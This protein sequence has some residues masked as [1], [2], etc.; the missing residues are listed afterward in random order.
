MEK[1]K[2]IYIAALRYAYNKQGEGFTWGDLQNELNL[3]NQQMS[4]VQ[5][6]LRSNM[7]IKDNLVDHF[8]Q[9][10]KNPNLL[11]LTQKGASEAL[12]YIKQTADRNKTYNH[13]VIFEV[14]G[15]MQM[16][17][18]IQTDKDAIVVAK[19]K[20]NYTSNKGK[21]IQGDLTS[22]EWYER[23]SGILMLTIASGLVIAFLIFKFGW[24]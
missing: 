18:V 19:V 8:Y 9:S 22:K 6:L 3:D 23:P 1:D 12:K 17:G 2:N 15:N 4:W 11:T 10:D 24:N 16:D 21:I 7:P 20:G 13:G 5:K 14:G